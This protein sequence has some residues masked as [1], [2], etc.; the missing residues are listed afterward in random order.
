MGGLAFPVSTVSDAAPF[1]A[2]GWW[3]EVFLASSGGT[4]PYWGGGAKTAAATS[5]PLWRPAGNVDPLFANSK[6]KN[7]RKVRN[8]QLKPKMSDDSQPTKRPKHIDTSNDTQIEEAEHIGAQ[9]STQSAIPIG[10]E[11]KLDVTS[12][13]ESFLDSDARKTIGDNLNLIPT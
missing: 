2:A 8:Y 11:A 4:S 3:R 13:S 7:F 6:L 10:E 5:L 12:S 9:S 1:R